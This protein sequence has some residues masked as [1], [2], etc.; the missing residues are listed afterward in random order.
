MTRVRDAICD[1]IKDTRGEK[2]WPPNP[3]APPN[4]PLFV[5]LYRNTCSLY[6]DMAGTSLHR[7]GY[8]SAMAKA[9]LNEAAAAGILT[10][11]GWPRPDT[12]L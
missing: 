8:R 7:R 3:E 12:G 1:A 6:R 11:A 9:P 4:V 10:L 2:L 5:A